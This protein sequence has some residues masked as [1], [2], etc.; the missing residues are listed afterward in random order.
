MQRKL[1][2]NVLNLTSDEGSTYGS[3]SSLGNRPQRFFV[4]FFFKNYKT[5]LEPAKINQGKLCQHQHIFSSVNGPLFK[6]SGIL[7][8]DVLLGGDFN[9]PFFLN[10]FSSRKRSSC[11]NKW[12]LF[13]DKSGECGDCGIVS[14]PHSASSVAVKCIARTELSWSRIGNFWVVTV[15]RILWKNNLESDTWRVYTRGTGHL[16]RYSQGQSHGLV[17]RSCIALLFLAVYQDVIMTLPG[18]RAGF[19]IGFVAPSLPRHWA[20]QRQL[21]QRI[22]FSSQILKDPK[23]FQYVVCWAVNGWFPCDEFLFAIVKSWGTHLSNFVISLIVSRWSQ[24]VNS[25]AS[26]FLTGFLTLVL[27]FCSTTC[28]KWAL[29]VAGCGLSA[30]SSSKLIFLSKPNLRGTDTHRLLNKPL[31]CL[32]TDKRLSPI[33][34]ECYRQAWTEVAKCNCLKNDFCMPTSSTCKTISSQHY[35]TNLLSYDAAQRVL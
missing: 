15:G 2:C 8:V 11:P 25:G 14:H 18:C 1:F 23:I 16:I 10:W 35:L 33:P 17:R 26:S 9:H 24:T 32:L 29:S 34:A 6:K 27:G 22:H 3:R 7:G 12:R 5:W 31:L 28:F 4:F 19:G 21:S 13:G 20:E 30:W